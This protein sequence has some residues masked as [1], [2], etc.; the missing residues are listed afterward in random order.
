MGDRNGP[1]HAQHICNIKVECLSRCHLV[2][3]LSLYFVKFF[4][5]LLIFLNM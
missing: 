5:M 1:E 2:W 3:C 4:A